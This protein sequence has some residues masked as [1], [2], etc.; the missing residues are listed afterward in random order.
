MYILQIGLLGY[1]LYIYHPN[2]YEKSS[3]FVMQSLWVMDILK[4]IP[5]SIGF[6]CINITLSVFTNF[7]GYLCDNLDKQVMDSCLAE[8]EA[9]VKETYYTLQYVKIMFIG[10]LVTTLYSCVRTGFLLYQSQTM[11]F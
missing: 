11:N 5:L 7:M 9:K 1:T 2:Q 8:L 10:L 6:H 3:L 4:I